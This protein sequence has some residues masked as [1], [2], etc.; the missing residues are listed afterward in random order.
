[1]AEQPSLPLRHQRHHEEAQ[2]CSAD[3][4]ARC[5]ACDSRARHNGY[6]RHPVVTHETSGDRRAATKPA[7][8]TDN[9]RRCSPRGHMGAHEGQR[10]PEDRGQSA[11][12][13]G[14]HWWAFGTFG[15][16]GAPG[17]AC[18]PS[19]VGGR[20][21]MTRHRSSDAIDPSLPLVT[22]FAVTHSPAIL[23]RPMW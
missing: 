21:V 6:P 22:N 4:Q 13:D 9:L 19:A 7:H 12:H 17:V 11:G 2:R 15:D 14:R 5:A 8:R 20:V 1:M 10:L 3:L 16:R 18:A 23:P